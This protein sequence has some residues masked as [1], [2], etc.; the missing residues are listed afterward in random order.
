MKKSGKQSE[1]KGPK[2]Y[3]ETVTVM[4]SNDKFGEGSFVSVSLENNV[5]LK[6]GQRLL[7]K[8][9]AK[10]AKNGASVAFLEILPPMEEKEEL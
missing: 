10:Q 3:N 2:K 4:F 9:S 5:E 1:T 7:F 8:R 6:A